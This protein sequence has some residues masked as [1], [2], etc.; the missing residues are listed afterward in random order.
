MKLETE[1]SCCVHVKQTLG[2][3]PSAILAKKK[4]Y[5]TTPLN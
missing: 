2:K 4:F 1:I 3:A 5:A